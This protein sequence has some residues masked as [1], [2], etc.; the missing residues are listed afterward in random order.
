MAVWTVEQ[1]GAFLDAAT[2]DR[3]YPLLHLIADRGLR[4]GEAVGLRWEDVD[5]GARSMQI[6][7]QVVQL[8]WAT[9][10]GA[11]KTDS[12]ARTVSLDQGTAEVLRRWRRIQEDEMRV[13]GDRWAETGYVFTREDGT[14]VHPDLASDGFQ[15]LLRTARLPPIRLHDLRHTAASLALQAGVPMKV[16]SEQ[17]GHSSLA[18]TADTYTSILPGVAK[19]A[20]EAVAAVMP[21]RPGLGG[22]HRNRPRSQS[23]HRPT[24]GRLRPCPAGP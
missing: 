14:P 19:A 8:G 9:E 10:I 1:T 17:L 3:L 18:I 6:S 5:L 23:V 11:P 2:R 21:R 24:P 15:R 16:V 22:T 20:A 13:P 7:Q 12:G 4:R